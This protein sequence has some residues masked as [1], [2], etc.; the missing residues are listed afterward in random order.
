MCCKFLVVDDLVLLNKILNVC[1][2]IYATDCWEIR[3]GDPRTR[4]SEKVLE[5]FLSKLSS[6]VLKTTSSIVL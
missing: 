3:I 1:L 2:P 5:A 6:R 4:L